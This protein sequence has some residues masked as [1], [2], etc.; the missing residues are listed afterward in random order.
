MQVNKENIFGTSG[1][2]GF[3]MTS[4]KKGISY[5]TIM[6]FFPRRHKHSGFVF[7]QRVRFVFGVFRLLFIKKSTLMSN[8]QMNLRGVSRISSDLFPLVF[9]LIRIVKIS[10]RKYFKSPMSNLYCISHKKL[11]QSGVLRRNQKIRGN[12]TIFKFLRWF[13]ITDKFFF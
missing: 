13:G 6:M 9:P 10:F 4:E 3:K 12:H 8:N 1:A 7:G 5:R 2:V 11:Y